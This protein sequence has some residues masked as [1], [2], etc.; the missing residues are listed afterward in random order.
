MSE[1]FVPDDFDPPLSFQ[2]PGFHLEPLGAVHSERDYEAWISSIEHIHATPGEWGTWPHPM[3]LEEN[4][5]DL[6]GHAGEFAAR[7]A[8]AY[9]VLDGKAVIGCLYIN[10]DE[11]GGTDAHVR[12]WVTES[13][14]AMDRVV[15]S[16]VNAWLKEQWPFRSFR[17]AVRLD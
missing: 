11:E 14:A 9:S 17:Y 16:T 4:L 7:E 6:E 10:P 1:P 5:A 12:S 8:F 3:T 13:R 2:G 15:W